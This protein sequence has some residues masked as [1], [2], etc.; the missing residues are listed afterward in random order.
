MF[1]SFGIL[2]LLIGIIITI[3]MSNLTLQESDLLTNKTNRVCKFLR[4]LLEPK[5]TVLVE[6]IF[7]TL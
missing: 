2:N 1:A 3:I 5:S 4:S 7:Q 6:G